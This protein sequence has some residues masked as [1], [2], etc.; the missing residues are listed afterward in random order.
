MIKSKLLNSFFSVGIQH[1]AQWIQSFLTKEKLSRV[2]EVGCGRQLLGILTLAGSINERR[3]VT[4]IFNDTRTY[5]PILHDPSPLTRLQLKGLIADGVNALQSNDYDV[6]VLCWPENAT[7]KDDDWAGRCVKNFQGDWVIYLGQAFRAWNIANP[8][9]EEELHSRWDCYAEMVP[10]DER[11]EL[12]V[13]G[14]NVCRNHKDVQHLHARELC[15]RLDCFF[16][17]VFY[18][19]QRKSRKRSRG[20][21]AEAGPHA[22]GYPSKRSKQA[23]HG[24][25]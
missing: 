9:L 23:D 24:V 14:R 1:A 13:C 2:L 10:R 5:E 15:T 7:S 4:W 19:F 20:F 21:N 18:I 3:K 12:N 16:D 11:Q 22:N 17:G 8:V 6:L 25:A